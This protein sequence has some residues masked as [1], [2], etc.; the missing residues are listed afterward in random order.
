MNKNESVLQTETGKHLETFVYRVPKRNHNAVIANLKKFVPWF[1]G[2]GV[3]IEY[4]QFGE[5][6]IME[7]MESIAKTLSAADDEEIWMELQYFR[8]LQHR[9]D[10]YAKMMRDKTI[11]PLGTE[12]FGLVSQGKPL[13]AGG[14]KKLE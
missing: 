5:G 7:G 2:Q 6:E 1:E 8:D 10:V 13:V 14:F 4:Y 9:K 11:E 3:R 12:F